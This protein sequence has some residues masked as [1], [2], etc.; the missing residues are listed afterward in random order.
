MTAIPSSESAVSIPQ[1]K[2]DQAIGILNELDID[3]WLTFVRE[4]TENGDP[5]LPLILDQ[6]LTWQSALIFT[7]SGEKIAIVGRHEDE[8]V[9][10]TGVYSDVVTYVQG[11]SKPL[12]ATLERLDP[13]QIAINFSPNDVKADGLSHGMYQLLCDYLCKTPFERRL[14]S[15]EQIIRALRGRKTASE[16]DRIREAV[17]TAENIL[18]DA[19][20]AITPGMTERA[21]SQHFHN[22]V[23]A[24]GLMTAWEPAMCPI[25]TT[26][27]NS[28]VGHGLPSD[29]LTVAPG[30]I[31]HIDFGVLENDYCSDLQRSWYV[32]HKGEQSPPHDVMHAFETVVLAIQRAYEAL[33]PGV[34]GFEIDAVARKTITDAGFPEYQHA[35]G[36]HV[37]RAAH[38]GGGVL[39]PQWERYGR[40]PF[41]PV[42]AGNV[43]TLE[44]GVDLP[45]RGYLGLEEMA[46]VTE[47]GAEWLS[48]PQTVLPLLGAI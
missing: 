44:L 46:V 21:V 6:P 16:V 34:P 8:A 22:E 48:S 1:E 10:S 45:D 13:R 20:T 18:H 17:A 12:V 9:E 42:E 24:R 26:G 36:H 39:G 41:F 5:V 37:G 14:T 27:P 2:A 11:V 35:T 25:V 30:G 32:P 28:M 33:K 29:T 15:A 31:F 47:S 4:T 40:T 3:C 23:V 19:H 43:V 38:D 7:K